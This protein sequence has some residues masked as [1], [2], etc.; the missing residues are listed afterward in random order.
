[1]GE[2]GHS[3][4]TVFFRTHSQPC[5]VLLLQCKVEKQ[6]PPPFESLDSGP[7]RPCLPETENLV[8]TISPPRLTMVVIFFVRCT[9][10]GLQLAENAGIVR[11]NNLIY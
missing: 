8:S 2:P 7:T 1:M 4:R 10:K 9:F 6:T 11:R 5:F 3:A